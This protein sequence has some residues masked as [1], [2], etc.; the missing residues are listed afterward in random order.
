[1][2]GGRVL[3]QVNRLVRGAPTEVCLALNAETG[4]EL[5][6]TPLDQAEYPDAGTGSTDGPRSTPSIDGDRVYVLTS[7]LRLY[8]LRANDGGVVWL[9][10]FLKEFPG[11][12]VIDWQNAASP[13]VVGDL[14]YLNSNV[15][16][17]R[18]TAVRKSDGVTV[19]SGQ[20]DTMTHAT[21]AYAT[22]AGKPQVVFLTLLGLVGVVPETGA[23]L[24]RYSFSPSSTSTAA[25]PVIAN[26][27]V[28]A[29]CAYARGA[30]TARVTQNGGTFS[31]GQQNYTGASSSYQNHWATPV[32]HEGHL[33]SIVERGSKSFACFSLETR[34]NRWLT[35]TVGSGN[36]G[37]GSLIKVGD[38]LVVLTEGG[39]LVLVKPNPE[40]YTEISRFQALNGVSWNH[41]AFA[42]GRLYARSSEE[43]IVLDVGVA[44]PP[45]PALVLDAAPTAPGGPSGF[46]IGVTAAAGG[47]LDGS[48][49]NRLVLE[50]ASGLS[51]TGGGWT[52]EAAVFQ[53]AGAG[54]L[55]TTVAVS[56]P[57]MAR[58][59][60]V[61]ERTP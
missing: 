35:S 40:A 18:L 33:Y 55:E 25:T 39:E 27:V 3:T 53:A 23:V 48:A 41:P 4:A 21:P 47:N 38:T 10:D 11:N 59:Y 32:H 42:D 43:I 24:W 30:W 13:L 12:R 15:S 57:E 17:K 26:D 8:C 19:W 54:R 6:A 36:P 5:W 2:D 29:S 58:Y 20:S 34:R 46:R 52:A 7:Y 31:V 9:R 61:R 16:G 22:I 50:S 14:I 1:M 44:L 56:Q 51:A 28:Y 37:Y 49:A 45:L 60:R